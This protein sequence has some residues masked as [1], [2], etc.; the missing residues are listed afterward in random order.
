MHRFAYI[1]IEGNV[2]M[3]IEVDIPHSQG[4]GQER[5]PEDFLSM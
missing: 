4:M 1:L 2:N 3:S 5:S